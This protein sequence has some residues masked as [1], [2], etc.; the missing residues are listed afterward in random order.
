[1]R[2]NDLQFFY[3]NLKYE[4]H[5]IIKNKI[6]LFRAITLFTFIDICNIEE[7]TFNNLVVMEQ[8]KLM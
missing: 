6:L 7:Q 3:L 4:S 2:I 1:M 5:L 8:I